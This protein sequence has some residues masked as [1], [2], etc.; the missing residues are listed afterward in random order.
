MQRK[1]PKQRPQVGILGKDLTRR[2]RGRC[3]LCLG[4]DEARALELHPFDKEP[5]MNRALMCCGRC[6]AWLEGS[7]MDVRD[8]QFLASAAWS[9]H[10][11]VRLAAGRLLLEFRGVEQPWVG[12]ALAAA[13]VDSGTREFRNT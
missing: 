4:R 5:S 1:F 12:E 6:R 8:A 3:E 9:P 7:E 2:S 13:D 11:P 10:A